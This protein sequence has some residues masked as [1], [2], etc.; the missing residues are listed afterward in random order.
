MSNKQL[1]FDVET[2]GTESNS[3][4]LCASFLVYDILEDYDV[5]LEQLRARVKTFKLSVEDQRSFG[6]KIDSGTLDFWKNEIAKVPE[7]KAVLK[8]DPENDL[9]M[10]QFYDEL[11]AWLID[12]GY[13]RKEDWIWQRGTLDI[14]ILDSIW[15]DLEINRKDFPLFWWKV[16][17]LR[18]A[19]DLLGETNMNGYIKN[20]K[21]NAYKYITNFKKHDPVDDIILEVLQLR[22]IGLYQK[23]E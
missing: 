14:M 13:N 2:L 19:V 7:L 11:Y 6:R 16:R 12:Q 20:I 5:S 3:V 4:C 23:V 17:D 8:R 22:M 1:I 9:T 15:K 18:T 21:E 10:L